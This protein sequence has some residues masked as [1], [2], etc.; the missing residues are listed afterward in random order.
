[1]NDKRVGN[2]ILILIAVIIIAVLVASLLPFGGRNPLT[3]IQREFNEDKTYSIDGIEIID[4]GTVSTPVNIVP[5]DTDEIRVHYYG[6]YNGISKLEFKMELLNG[7]LHVREV[8]NEGTFSLNLSFN[9][10]DLKLDIYIPK[11][12]AN[13]LKINTVSGQVSIEGQSLRSLNVNTVSGA[14]DLKSVHTASSNLKTV[15]GRITASGFTGKLDSKTVSGEM[16]AHFDEFNGDINA[17]T[18]SGQI[19]LSLPANAEFKLKA[20]TVSGNI[21]CDFPVTVQGTIRRNNME[22]TA[23]GGDHQISLTSVS[24]NIIINK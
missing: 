10:S 5:V 2:I 6:S 12:Y 14:L 18:T 1:M 19:R 3:A 15:S 9:R 4:A 7:R 13:D 16:K 20:N 17:S 22:G 24:G 8:F 11:T 21:E 23:G